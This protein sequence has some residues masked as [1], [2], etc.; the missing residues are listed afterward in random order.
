M[1]DW[2]VIVP[3][4]RFRDAKQRLEGVGNRAA[5]AEALTRDTLE[6]VASSSRVR[7]VLVMTDDPQ[8]VDD[9]RLPVA[10]VVRTQRSPGLNGAISDGL[11]YAGESWPDFGVAVLQGDLPA[12]TAEDLDAVLE[13]AEEVPL[14]IVPDADG[15]GTAMITGTPGMPLLPAFGEGSAARHQEL[16]HKPIRASERLRRD[17]DTRADLSA[18]VRL[19][20]GRHTAAVLELQA[21]VAPDSA[22]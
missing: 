9:L 15:R 17:V 12:L 21:A 5:L 8:L 13:S 2:V 6:A 16:G 10:A 4:K 19:G 3:V 11:A 22:A 14:G 18:A 7:M 1:V 20:V